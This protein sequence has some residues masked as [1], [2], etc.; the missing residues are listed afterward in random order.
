MG[1]GIKKRGDV[2]EIGRI[3]SERL[4]EQQYKEGINYGFKE[5]DNRIG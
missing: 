3:M 1:I 4:R 2:N 5:Q